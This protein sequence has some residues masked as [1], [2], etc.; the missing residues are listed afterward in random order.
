MNRLKNLIRV[1]G[2]KLK[3]LKRL[4]GISKKLEKT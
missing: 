2:E 4:S 1:F 3:N